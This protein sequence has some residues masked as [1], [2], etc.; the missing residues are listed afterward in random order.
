MKITLDVCPQGMD[1]IIAKCLKDSLELVEKCISED[2]DLEYN[3]ELEYALKVVLE[4]YTGEE[5]DIKT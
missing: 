4:Y 3:R 1:E 5:R 2:N